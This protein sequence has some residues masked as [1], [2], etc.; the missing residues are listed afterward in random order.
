VNVSPR[1]G[2]RSRQQFH[3]VSVPS[4]QTTNIEPR[5]SLGQ[6]SPLSSNPGSK[7]S[8]YEES[9]GPSPSPLVSPS[10]R[11]SPPLESLALKPNPLFYNDRFENVP[12]QEVPEGTELT[13]PSQAQQTSPFAAEFDSKSLPP[14]PPPSTHQT[15]PPSIRRTKDYEIGSALNLEPFDPSNIALNCGI[16]EPFK[17]APT[18]PRDTISIQKGP[19]YTPHRQRG[20]HLFRKFSPPTSVYRPDE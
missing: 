8:S 17:R 7:P 14:V 2:S 16:E 9:L 20:T 3:R 11:N 12:L 6:F 5:S 4:I 10:G 13:V 19:Y 1:I 15:A 18:L